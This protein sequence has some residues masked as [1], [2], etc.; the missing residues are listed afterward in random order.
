MIIDFQQGIITYPA[1]GSV[2]QFLTYSNGYVSFSA[3]N[4]HTE[5][6]FTH[7]TDNYLVNESVSISNAWGPITPGV[8]SWL[9]WDLNAR[10]A[11]RTFGVT[12]IQPSYGPSQPASPVNDQHWFDT[13]AKQMKV[14]KSSVNRWGVVIRVFAARITVS[15]V[16]APMGSNTSSPYAGTQ[17][18]L[19]A[20][21]VRVG[22]II[23]DVEGKPVRRS[24]GAFFTTE[25]QF[26]TNGSPVNTMRLESLVLSA[27]AGEPMA[28]YQVAQYSAFGRVLLATY[29]DTQTTVIAMTMES[30]DTLQTGAVGIQGV[31]TNP[32]WNWT[33]VGVPLWIHGTVPGYLTEVDPHIVDST[34]FPISKPPVA[35]VISPQTVYFD[36][37]IGGYGTVIEGNGG[38][39]A[40]YV[41]KAGDTMTGALT[42]YGNPTDT[43]HAVPKQYVDN[44]TLHDLAGVTLTSPVANQI[45]RFNGTEWVNATFNAVG[46]RQ[47]FVATAN[48]TLFG[49]LNAEYVPGAGQMSVYINGIKQYPGTFTEPSSTTVDLTSP[50]DDSDVIMVEV[51]EV[52]PNYQQPSYTTALNQL[53]DVTVTSPSSTQVLTFN[54]TEWVNSAPPAPPISLDELT[55][56]V[57][58]APANQDL[59]A[60]NGAGWINTNT[61]N[62]AF[63]AGSF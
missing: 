55:D 16:L 32:N 9:Y 13:N 18:G 50:S 47:T 7:S 54:G 17:V 53:T 42:L 43:L 39:S 10:T 4:G 28:P 57:I 14:F 6:A 35:R 19:T 59:L 3:A 26:F 33:Q 56:V 8:K 37:G 40:D 30:I 41:A 31:I 25:D 1:S 34:M 36:Q 29:N 5:I 58:A 2:Q 44:R 61:T 11:V 49:P 62:L 15:N 60:Y 23:I 46:F 38:V 27:T 20:P 21:D 24:T 12:Y 45:L 51:S 63:D 48:Q 52:S 22:S